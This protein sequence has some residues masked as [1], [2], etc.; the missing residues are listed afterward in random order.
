MVDYNTIPEGTGLVEVDPSGK[1]TKPIKADK[2]A[3]APRAIPRRFMASILRAYKLQHVSS[4]S[5]LDKP[6]L[7]D[8]PWEPGNDS[9]GG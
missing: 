3:D 9:L 5:K 4:A 2:N 8:E 6:D 1:I 7:D